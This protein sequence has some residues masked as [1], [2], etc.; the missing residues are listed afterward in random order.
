MGLIIKKSMQ[1]SDSFWIFDVRIHQ[2]YEFYS[3]GN[4]VLA[5][6]LLKIRFFSLSFSL[7]KWGKNGSSYLELYGKQL[8]GEIN[9]FIRIKKN[10]Y[11][12]LIN[13]SKNLNFF[14][15]SLNTFVVE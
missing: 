6:E 1:I 10:I 14:K 15:C 13:L 8:F 9:I 5:F 11:F 7:L 4:F 2:K 3:T 12:F